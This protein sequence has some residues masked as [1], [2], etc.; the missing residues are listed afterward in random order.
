MAADRTLFNRIE[1]HVF[2]HCETTAGK[3]TTVGAVAEALGVACSEIVATIDRD[4]YWIFVMKTTAP[5]ATWAIG[6]EGE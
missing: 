5:M 6:L 3:D 4:A 2:A 1:A